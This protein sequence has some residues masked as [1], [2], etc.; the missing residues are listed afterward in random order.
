VARTHLTIPPLTPQDV[1]RFWKKVHIRD[2][3][4][5]WPWKASRTLRSYGLLGIRRGGNRRVNSMFLAHRV[6]WTISNNPI[7]PGLCVLHRCDNPPCCNPAHLFLGTP[8][9]NTQD[10]NQKGR[11][12]HG[13]KSAARKHPERVPRGEGHTMHK[14]TDEQVR[15]IR[16]RHDAG[17]GSTYSL[18]IEYR[19]ARATISQVIRRKTWA[20]V[21]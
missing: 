13:D 2:L 7:P 19:V 12:A 17:A 3:N 1:L 18:A 20:H 15:E 21:A 6:A 11:L 14:L 10:A 4:E 8:A 5:C 9:D 16:L